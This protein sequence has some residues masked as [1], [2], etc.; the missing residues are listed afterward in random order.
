MNEPLYTVRAIDGDVIDFVED[1]TTESLR[2]DGLRWSEAVELCRLSFRQGFR[3][4]IWQMESGEDAG[5]NDEQPEEALPK[6][7]L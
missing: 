7:E 2:Y 4:V 3:C 5:G 1:V 6:K